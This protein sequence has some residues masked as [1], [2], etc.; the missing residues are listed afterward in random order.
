MGSHV[1]ARPQ[2]FDGCTRGSATTQGRMRVQHAKHQQCVSTRACLS[3]PLA[4]T[5]RV[6]AAH[7]VSADV[8]HSLHTACH[9]RHRAAR[10]ACQPIGRKDLLEEGMGG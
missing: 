4:P 9:H 8:V 1:G 7:L 6:R 10:L 5:S 3:C 2:S